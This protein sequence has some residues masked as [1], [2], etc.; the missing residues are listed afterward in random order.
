M[1]DTEPYRHCFP[2]TI[3]RHAMWLYHRFPLSYRDVQKLFHQHDIKISH[4]PL[5]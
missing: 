1:T 5:L 4:E 3:I 2:V